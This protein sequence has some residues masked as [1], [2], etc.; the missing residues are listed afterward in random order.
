MT[1][2]KTQLAKFLVEAK[3]RTYAAKGDEATM[4]PLLEDTK[5]LEYKQGN[6]TYRDIYAGMTFFAGQEIVYEGNTVLWSMVYSGGIDKKI[7]D[8]TK[9]LK[10]YTFLRQCLNE[11]SENYPFRG[12][13]KFVAG[14]LT[15]QNDIRGNL[16][17]FD[18]VE[19]IFLSGSLVY[20]LKYSGGVLQ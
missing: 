11:V 6:Y 13:K 14:Q 10:I 4:L 20:Q 19:T 16:N 2:E 18:G 17:S 5:Q 15:Y 3:K 8:E 12:P 9:I 7:N 1:I